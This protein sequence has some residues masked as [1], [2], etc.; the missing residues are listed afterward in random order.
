M[1]L[2]TKIFIIKT[3]QQFFSLYKLKSRMERKMSHHTYK[4]ANFEALW[5]ICVYVCVWLSVFFN[6]NAFPIIKF[7]GWTLLTI[8]TR[9]NIT[10][11]TSIE[12]KK[13]PCLVNQQ[14]LRCWIISYKF[15]F[16]L[17]GGHRCHSF[18]II[19]DHPDDR[20]FQI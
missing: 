5:R 2:E 3:C 8:K 15:T 11:M 19:Y 9:K 1:T 18:H 14:H 17:K 4:Y 16:K 20:H 7:N 12:E 6:S 13:P 10:K